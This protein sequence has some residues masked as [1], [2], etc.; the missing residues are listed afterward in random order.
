[1]T[2][3]ITTVLVL[4]CTLLAPA[5]RAQDASAEVAELRQLLTELRT[6]YEA[7]ITD[8]EA[9]LARAE[10][11]A[12]RASR[13]AEDA[14]D[15]AE[16]AA[17][18]QSAGASAPN[19]F[20]PG[21]GAIL[22]GRYA[23]FDSGWEELPGFQPGGEIGTGEEGFALGEAEINLKASVD[24]RYFGNLTLGIHEEDGAAEVGIEE[25]WLQTTDLPGGLSVTGGRLFSAAG[26]LNGFHFHADDFVDRP[27]PYQAFLGGRYS[28]DG[29]QARWVAPTALLLELGAEANWGGSFPATANHETAPGSW[30]LFTKLGGDVGVSHSWQ[31]GLAR[32]MSDA[33][34]RTGGHPHEGEELPGAF[35]GDSD[36][37]IADFVWKWAPDGNPNVRNLKVQG[38]F[39]RRSEDGVFEDLDYSGDQSGWYLQSAWQFRP[40]WRFGLRYDSISADSNALVAGT[41]LQ[42]P[43]RD[44]TRT[45]AMLDWSPSEFS[46]LRLQYVD[47]RV[48]PDADSQWYL[49]YIMG[50]GAH[51]A[52]QF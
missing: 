23:S 46:R 33:V 50:I 27:L 11:L 10:Q 49:Q 2:T 31:L 32:I 29:L 19:A 14:V 21:I 52:H 15:A 45:S 44:A 37:W 38:E 39:F 9:R 5:A 3:R 43:G 20:N 7:R 42:D 18:A 22:I 25:A 17:T 8:L 26:Y 40:M 6:D 13:E 41:E 51:G 30:T 12:G 28:V 1:M 48:L 34:D 36:L 24:T 35:T 4:L 16:Q 47:D